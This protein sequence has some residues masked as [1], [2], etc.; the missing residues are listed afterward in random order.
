MIKQVQDGKAI[1][2]DWVGTLEN[3]A[4]VLTETGKNVAAGTAEKLAEVEAGLKNGTINVFDTK[5]FTVK[6]ETLTSYKA[7]VDSDEAF[8]KDTEVIENGIFMESK[9]RSAPYF[10]IQIDGINLLD[11]AF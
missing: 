11:T 5:N 7:D 3:G 6:K 1:D 2:T 9:F 10:D 8:A 4:V